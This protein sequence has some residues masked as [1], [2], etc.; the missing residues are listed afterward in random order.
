MEKFDQQ[1]YI[2]QYNSTHY[3]QLTVRLPIGKK[4]LI[5]QHAQNNGMSVNSYIIQL[6]ENDMKKAEE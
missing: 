3:E 2:N 1:K 5:K 6:I 4:Q